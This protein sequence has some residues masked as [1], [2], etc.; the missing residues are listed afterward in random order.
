MDS[1]K[2]RVKFGANEF[3]AEGPNET[4]TAHLQRFLKDLPFLGQSPSSSPDGPAI[5]GSAAER[6]DYRECV[7]KWT[8]IPIA[9]LERLFQRSRDWLVH[10]RRLPK[11]SNVMLDSVVL[12]IYGIQC[13]RNLWEGPCPTLNVSDQVMSWGDQPASANQVLLSAHESG[14][15]IDRIDRVFA[16]KPGLNMVFSG[17]SKRGSHYSLTSAGRDHAT[18]LA[19]VMLAEE[20]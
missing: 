2:L 9:N 4:V 18:N 17:G 6:R 7:S 12:L 8:T 1:I 13:F 16:T 5:M 20:Q 15:D 11:T 10:L 3:D 14:L 19:L